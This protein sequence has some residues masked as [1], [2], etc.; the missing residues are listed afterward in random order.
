M[1]HEEKRC[2]VCHAEIPKNS[3]AI[4][5]CKACSMAAF[6]RRHSKL[7]LAEEGLCYYNS[8]VLCSKKACEKC[9]WNPVVEKRRKEALV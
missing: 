4:Y 6:R 2:P 1:E 3:K 8:E 7:V 9:G 5:C